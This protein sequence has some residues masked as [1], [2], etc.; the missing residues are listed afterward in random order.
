MHKQLLINPNERQ[1]TIAQGCTK[2]AAVLPLSTIERRCYRNNDDQSVRACERRCSSSNISS[3]SS[4][5]NI[6][7]AAI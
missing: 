6:S 5:S 4:D 3:S 7:S 1:T 2:Q